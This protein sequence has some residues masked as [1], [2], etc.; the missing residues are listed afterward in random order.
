MIF[1]SVLIALVFEFRLDMLW[2]GINALQI[3]S[4]MSYTS[5]AWPANISFLFTMLNQV[6]LF[7]FFLDPFSVLPSGDYLFDWNW[8]PTDPE[9]NSLAL[10]NGGSLTF[11]PNL[12]FVALFLL[13][14]LLYSLMAAI[15]RLLLRFKVCGK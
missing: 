7:D 1:A 5:V 2:G 13:I 6:T 8:S 15:G 10:A 14:A 4:C 9:G 11:L 3:V 12:G